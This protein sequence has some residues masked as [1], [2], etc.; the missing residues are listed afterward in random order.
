[1]CVCREQGNL[2]DLCV[3][4]LPSDWHVC[5]GDDLGS[6]WSRCLGRRSD[7][8]DKYVTTLIGSA[9]DI[10]TVTNIYATSV[11]LKLPVVFITSAVT[12]CT[13]EEDTGL[14]DGERLRK[15]MLMLPINIL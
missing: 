10:L 12:Y 1:M 11:F 5:D 15:E 4:P 7:R 8:M 13:M 9:L 3:D 2:P 6:H 14:Y